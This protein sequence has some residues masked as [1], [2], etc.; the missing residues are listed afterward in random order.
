VGKILV[1]GAT[2]NIGSQLVQRLK[3]RNLEVI[4][5][6][7]SLSKAGR[8]S[9]QS[10]DTA[11]LNFGQPDSLETAFDGVDRLFLLL[12]LEEPMGVWG[13]RVIDAAQKAGVRFI[14]RSSGLG[15]GVQT[16][17]EL[18]EV[19]G[20]IDQALMSSGLAYT[21]V[22]PNSFMQ[23]YINYFGG[24]IK[25][26]QSIFLPQ[27]QGRI[28]LIDVRDIAAVDAEILA[29]PEKHL[30]KTYDLTGP[31]ALN[32][33]ELAL[34]LSRVTGKPI[35]YVDIDEATARQGLAQMGTPEWNIRLLESLNR[36]IKLGMASELTPWVRTIIGKPPTTFEQFARDHVDAW[37]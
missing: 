36:R 2:G 21:V 20:R 9:K 26:Q 4:A 13:P 29:S 19:H 33:E 10:I 32:N 24:T 30:K 8:F 17:Y 23:N 31:E 15:A 18:G 3:E 16:G 34:I 27:G 35:T 11:I 37:K 1:T 12:P 28:S 5:G 6:V 22:R 7:S 25:T 14:L